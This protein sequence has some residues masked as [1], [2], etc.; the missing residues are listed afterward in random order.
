M[1]RDEL[2]TGQSPHGIYEFEVKANILS[3]HSPSY[4][5]TNHTQLT[6]SAVTDTPGDRVSSSAKDL[7]E[8]GGQQK[9]LMLE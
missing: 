6:D 9:P 8:R 4:V 7:T 2:I 5:K 1:S 3:F